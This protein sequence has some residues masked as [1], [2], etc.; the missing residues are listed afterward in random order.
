LLRELAHVERRQPGPAGLA[1][2]RAHGE[3][4][5]ALRRRAAPP[6]MDERRQRGR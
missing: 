4:W 2:R 5:A 1:A 3:H 6:R